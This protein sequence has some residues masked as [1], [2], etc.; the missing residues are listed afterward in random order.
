MWLTTVPVGLLL[1]GVW[2]PT[3]IAFASQVVP[4]TL[5]SL[6]ENPC[7]VLTLEQ[8][9][10]ATGVDVTR[11]QRV[12]GI[13]KIVQAQ[14]EQREPGAGS[15]CTYETR[16]DFGE[17]NIHVPPRTERRTASYWEA[18]EKYFRSFPGSAQTIPSLGA[19][20]WLAGGAS[21]HVLA[22][23]DEYYTVST[24][25][26]QRRSRELVIALARAIL[27]RLER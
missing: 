17:I 4:G 3:A 5:A 27:G 14:R 9:A 7:A 18:R 21:L 16:S 2:I 15:I 13:P 19:D 22:R 26:Y 25:M 12:P 6:P 24:Q 11:M 20:A 10:A 8:V 23:D 1:S